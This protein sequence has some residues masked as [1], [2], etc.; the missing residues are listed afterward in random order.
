M[1]DLLFDFNRKR[2]DRI[3]DFWKLPHKRL[4]ITYNPLNQYGIKQIEPGFSLCNVSATFYPL[5]D[6]TSAVLYVKELDH[7]QDLSDPGDKLTDSILRTIVGP[8]PLDGEWKVL[9]EVTFRARKEDLSPVVVPIPD[10]TGPKVFIF[11][12]DSVRV[13]VHGTLT[14]SHE[15]FSSPTKTDP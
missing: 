12:S 3:T 11:L 2:N 15:L 5:S 13:S 6:T 10:L 9:A 7:P 8:R 14:D 4:R 1:L